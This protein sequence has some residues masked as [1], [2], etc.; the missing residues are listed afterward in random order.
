MLNKS[1]LQKIDFAKLYLEQ[2]KLSSFAPKLASHW[3]TKSQALNKRVFK[4]TYVKEFLEKIELKNAKTLL[5]I[6]CGPGTF[7]ISLADKLEEVYCLDFSS[8]MLECVAQNA[9]DRGLKNVKTI[10]KSFYEDWS[11]VPKCDILIA[12]RCSIVKDAKEFL[13]L[14]NKKAKKIYLTSKVDGSFIDEEILNLLDKNIEPKP[15]YMYL[16]NILHEMNILV[17]VDFIKSEANRFIGLSLEEFLEKIS[18]DLGEINEDE[19]KRLSYYYEK[20][21]KNKLNKDYIYW[22]LIS[23]ETKSC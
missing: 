14:I 5:D 19:K 17:K 4:S 3:D 6:G 16:L 18:F 9:K 1:N 12:S 21:L 15:N 13:N 2:Q 20:N 7:G 23:Y 10:Q 22:A 11:N 8:K